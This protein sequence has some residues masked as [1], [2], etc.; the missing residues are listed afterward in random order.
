MRFHIKNIIFCSLIFIFA[1][2]AH[3]SDVRPH[4]DGIHQISLQADFKDAS[5]QSSEAMKQANHYCK[6]SGKQAFVVEEK[7]QYTGSMKES[8]YIAAKKAARAAEAVGDVLFGTQYGKHARTGETVGESGEAADD[9]I[10][11][12]YTYEMK[13]KCQ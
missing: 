13:F 2:C 12:G 6:E 10:G 4:A 3:H 8:D 9:V 1:A 7:C 5:D 11:K